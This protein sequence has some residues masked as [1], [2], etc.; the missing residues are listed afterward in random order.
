MLHIPFGLS[1]CQ[2]KREIAPACSTSVSGER[3]SFITNILSK[4]INLFIST[5]FL[6]VKRRTA[7]VIFM[8]KSYLHYMEH[9][10]VSPSLICS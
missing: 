6:F 9:E 3:A 8:T 2:C 10:Q 4:H 7:Y 1:E 5:I